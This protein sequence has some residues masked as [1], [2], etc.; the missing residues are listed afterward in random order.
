[1]ASNPLKWGILATGGIAQ[2][3]VTDILQDPSIRNANDIAHK[4]VAMG[5]SSSL[6]K[7]QEFVT[8]FIAP[9]TTTERISSYGSYEELVADQ[10][11]E[12]VYVASP[13]S[14]HYS[15]VM[16]AL[17]AGKHVLCEVSYTFLM[18]IPI[19]QLTSSQKP[20]MFQ[21]TNSYSKCS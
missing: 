5:S 3:F 17:E 10:N 19:F 2:T 8:K 6:I 7:A 16:L 14:H 9:L 15:N 1:M 12:I 11:V 13:Q 18:C 20:S 21:P 4:I